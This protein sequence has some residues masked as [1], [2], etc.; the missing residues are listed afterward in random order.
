MG[1]WPTDCGLPMLQNTSFL[2]GRSSPRRRARWC[3]RARSTSSPRTAYWAC[4]TETLNITAK[5]RK[6][7]ARTTR[8]LCTHGFYVAVERVQSQQPA[9]G[10]VCRI[11]STSHGA[12]TTSSFGFRTHGGRELCCKRAQQWRHVSVPRQQSRRLRVNESSPTVRRRRKWTIRPR[13]LS[14]NT[15]TLTHSTPFARANAEFGSHK[16]PVRAMRPN[17]SV[18]WR[19]AAT[20]VLA[21]AVVILSVV[22]ADSEHTTAPL[23]SPKH[24]TLAENNLVCTRR[25]EAGVNMT[26]IHARCLCQALGYDLAGPSATR[27]ATCTASSPCL[28]GGR[29]RI[30]RRVEHGRDALWV[31]AANELLELKAG[32]YHVEH[33]EEALWVAVANMLLKLKDGDRQGRPVNILK[34]AALWKAFANTLAERIDGAYQVVCQSSA[35]NDTSVDPAISESTNW[36]YGPLTPEMV[37]KHGGAR[38]CATE[39]CCCAELIA[40]ATATHARTVQNACC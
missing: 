33:E 30:R 35:D 24:Y 39:L 16:H 12:C 8:A 27:I 25:V 19:R 26:F 22:R 2:N 28:L 3:S 29:C 37:M 13:T 31:A 21:T 40:L 1:V 5:G 36:V 9:D 18:G 14:H 4:N 20:S 23:M 17:T 7:A 34:G 6:E 32:D 10:V 38:R 15:H 11:P